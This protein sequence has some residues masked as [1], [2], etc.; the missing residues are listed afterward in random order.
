MVRADPR[1]GRTRRPQTRAGTPSSS[2]RYS[3]RVVHGCLLPRHL[4][5]ATLQKRLGQKLGAPRATPAD[6]HRTRGLATFHLVVPPRNCADA[7]ARRAGGLDPAIQSSARGKA[8]PSCSCAVEAGTDAAT[9]RDPAAPTGATGL[10]TGAATAGTIY[11]K[12]PGAVPVPVAHT[13]RDPRRARTSAR[14]P[15]TRAGTSIRSGCER[16]GGSRTR[17]RAGVIL[18]RC[19]RSDFVP[20]G[21]SRALF[22]GIGGFLLP[23]R[24]SVPVA[25]LSQ[26]VPDLQAESV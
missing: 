10:S 20:A 17:E 23:A 18:A 26:K 24:A 15:G 14:S 19:L 1:R 9:T 5:H 13:G 4:L 12:H 25:Q 6:R 8:D 11:D 21:D 2:T 3:A 22:T 7:R 16:P